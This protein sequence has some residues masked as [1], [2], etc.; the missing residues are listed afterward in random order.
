MDTG[1][2]KR[3]SLKCYNCGTKHINAVPGCVCYLCDGDFVDEEVETEVI[4]GSA[5]GSY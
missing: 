5:E 2:C 4:Q 1:Q 3:E